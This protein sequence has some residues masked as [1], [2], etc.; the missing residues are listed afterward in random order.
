MASTNPANRA[1]DPAND[2][3]LR[4]VRRISNEAVTQKTGR[5]WEEWFALLDEANAAA[6]GHT[7]SARLLREQHGVSPSWAQA[8][9]VRYE[10]A[11]GLRRPGE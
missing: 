5:R 4:G 7:A 2:P 11:R 10:Y 6:L 8:V 9:T 1:K 3:A